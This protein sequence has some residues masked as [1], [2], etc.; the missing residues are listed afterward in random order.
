MAG[1]HSGTFSL[2]LA[3]FEPM[4]IL[5]STISRFIFAIP[6]GIFGLMHFMNGSEMASTMVPAWM[7][8]KIVLVYLTGLALVAAC[9]S[10]IIQKHTRLACVLLGAMLLIF[11]LTIWIPGVVGAADE[12]QMAMAMSM[13]LKDTALAGGAWILADRYSQSEGI[14]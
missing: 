6:F 5:T 3:P 11:V 8:L 14:D 9:I 7:P 13:L 1:G 2:Q 12:S 4:N 10:I